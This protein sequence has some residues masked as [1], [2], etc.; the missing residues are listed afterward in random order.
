MI[1]WVPTIV[2]LRL[3]RSRRI[4]CAAGKEDLDVVAAATIV[5]EDDLVGRRAADRG[6]LSGHEPEDVAPLSSFTNDEIGEFRHGL[7]ALLSLRRHPYTL[8]SVGWLLQDAGNRNFH[9]GRLYPWVVYVER[10]YSVFL[11]FRNQTE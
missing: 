7:S 1:R 9:A 8:S 5:L 3:S 11:V 10:L 6:R 4:H 2:P